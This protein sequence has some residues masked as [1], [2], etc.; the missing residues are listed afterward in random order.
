M[1]ETN[2]KPVR[3]MDFIG[4][5]RAAS[6]DPLISRPASRTASATHHS[7]KP[8]ARPASKAASVK[9][10]SE[11]DAKFKVAKT[12]DK[13]MIS[14]KPA[15]SR[16]LYPTVKDSASDTKKK[17]DKQPEPR[18]Q[19]PLVKAQKPTAESEKAPDNNSYSLGG[20]SP[21]LP[22]VSVEK[23]GLSS[24]VPEKKESHFESV[25]Y[26]GVN[27]SSEKSHKN[28][29]EKKDIIDLESDKSKK[30]KKDKKPVKIIDDKEKKSGIPLV[31]IIILTILLGAVVGTG[32]YLLLPK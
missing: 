10:S 26:L 22:N 8:A 1:T 29:Y 32:V 17:A 9:K 3:Y 6:T 28:I 5:R 15:T 7:V 30:K 25:S 20:K 21:F 12:S 18:E 14:R 13:P 19:K 27:D 2:T 16:D 24:S 23:R 31:V 4:T 11:P